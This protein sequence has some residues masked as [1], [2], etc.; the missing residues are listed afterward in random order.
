MFVFF[1]VPGLDP[2]CKCFGK[3]YQILETFIEQD[4]NAANKEKIT[5]LHW[6]C[7]NGHIEVIIIAASKSSFVMQHLRFF[8]TNIGFCR[9]LRN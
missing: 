5:A 7:L 9:W 4:L 1:S 8:L 6:A 3:T 2:D